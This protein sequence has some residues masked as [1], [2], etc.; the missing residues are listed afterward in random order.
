MKYLQLFL[1]GLIIFPN[2]TDQSPHITNIVRQSNTAKSL[3][4]HQNYSLVLIGGRNVPEAHS[5]HNIGA[6]VVA[7]DVLGRPG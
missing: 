2:G 5:E 3:N 6:P 1:L 4:K 7:P